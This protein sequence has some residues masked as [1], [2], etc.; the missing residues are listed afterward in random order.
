MSRRR[1]PLE[2]GPRPKAI[3]PVC[4]GWY[5]LKRD[6]KFRRHRPQLYIATL[7]FDAQCPGSD[8]APRRLNR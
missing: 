7:E 8:R 2:L 6:G 4:G 5:Q 1:A 3:C